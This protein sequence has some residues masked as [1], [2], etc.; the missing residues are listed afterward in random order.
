VKPDEPRDLDGSWRF[1]GSA[2]GS[3][4]L[5][6][7]LGNRE[8]LKLQVPVISAPTS[9]HHLVVRSAQHR[10]PASERRSFCRTD[11]AGRPNEPSLIA[12]RYPS[13]SIDL[14]GHGM[15][16]RRRGR[17][18]IDPAVVIDRAQRR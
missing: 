9:S 13:S 6:C 4:Q 18:T 3:V 11:P 16:T 7:S 12:S 1:S 15:E 5:F 8:I 17:Q 2:S 14:S 10:P